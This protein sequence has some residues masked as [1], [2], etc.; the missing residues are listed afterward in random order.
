MSDPKKKLTRAELEKREEELETQEKP[1]TY[2]E[3]KDLN[4]LKKRLERGE[5][6]TNDKYFKCNVCGKLHYIRIQHVYDYNL[7]VFCMSLF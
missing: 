2:E 7:M 4:R 5:I 3:Y 1:L 6:V